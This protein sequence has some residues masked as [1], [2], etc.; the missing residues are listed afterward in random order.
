MGGETLSPGIIDTVSV[1][2]EKEDGQ[3]RKG[4]S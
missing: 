3:R 2:I 4:K 1:V